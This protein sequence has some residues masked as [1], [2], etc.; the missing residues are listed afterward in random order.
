MVGGVAV[1]PRQQ[2]EPSAERVGDH[3]RPGYEPDSGASQR[4][5]GSHGRALLPRRERR[6]GRSARWLMRTTFAP[7]VHRRAEHS[8]RT[9]HRRFIAG[10]LGATHD[11]PAPATTALTDVSI[12]KQLPHG[13]R[14]NRAGPCP[15]SIAR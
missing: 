2:T 15:A 12:A 1:T 7:D 8:D 11:L 3:S 6:P 9:L 10:Q 4:S 14:E 5:S 13:R